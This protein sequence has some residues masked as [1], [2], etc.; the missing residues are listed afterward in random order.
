MPLSHGKSEKAFSKNVATEIKAGKPQDQALAIA[1]STQKAAKGKK[2]KGGTISIEEHTRAMDRLR[3][4]HAAEKARYAQGGAVEDPNAFMRRQ[5]EPA[6]SPTPRSPDQIKEDKEAARRKM[7]EGF[8]RMKPST[9]EDWQSAPAAPE[10][11]SDPIQEAESARQNK[12]R[13]RS[14]KHTPSVSDGSYANGGE[15]ASPTPTLGESI[16]DA[17]RRKKA[18]QAAAEPQQFA[19]GGQV[20]IEDN[21]EEEPYGEGYDEGNMDAV[22]KELYDVGRYGKIKAHMKGRKG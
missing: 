12:E 5:P 7:A 13:L 9:K 22:K 15:V 4:E 2:A 16:A 18:K 6:P 14:F 20:E 10:D 17:I 8:A 3:G 11:T 21:A 19:E 1:Y